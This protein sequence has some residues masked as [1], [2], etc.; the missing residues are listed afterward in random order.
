MEYRRRPFKGMEGVDK[1]YGADLTRKQKNT[2]LEF[3]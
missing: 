2:V 3:G 1:G